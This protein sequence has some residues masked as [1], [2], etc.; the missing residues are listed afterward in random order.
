[1]S[2]ILAYELKDNIGYEYEEEFNNLADAKE[3]LGD[4]PEHM[5]VWWDITDQDGECYGCD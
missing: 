4:L 3:R 1:M 5:I 2:L